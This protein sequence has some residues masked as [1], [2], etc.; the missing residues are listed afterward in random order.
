MAIKKARG[1]LDQHVDVNENNKV[2]EYLAAYLNSE[3]NF[4]KQAT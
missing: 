2:L 4:L 3:Q 1:Q